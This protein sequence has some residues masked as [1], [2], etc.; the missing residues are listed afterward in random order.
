MCVCVCVYCSVLYSSSTA[1][2]T[3]TVA[4][5]PYSL[6][7]CCATR[8]ATR[9]AEYLYGTYY[10]HTPIYS[11][12]SA[13]NLASTELN[14]AIVWCNNSWGYAVHEPPAKI[15]IVMQLPSAFWV[16]IVTFDQSDL[17]QLIYDVTTDCSILQCAS[18][19][20]M[21][22][23][24]V[25]LPSAHPVPSPANQIRGSHLLCYVNMIFVFCR[26][27]KCYSAMFIVDHGA[28]ETQK[29]L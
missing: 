11:L 8:H 15:A 26:S 4:H 9:H 14:P 10:D 7:H 28:I 27:L 22:Y 20:W 29:T 18:H 2:C 3:Y 16:L 13:D 23:I 5:T 12:Y 25:E 17:L 1:S 21:H 19:Q 24:I 6:G